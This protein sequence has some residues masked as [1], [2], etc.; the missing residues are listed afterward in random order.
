MHRVAPLQLAAQELAAQ[1]LAALELAPQELAAQELAAQELALQE[2]ALQE[3]APRELAVLPQLAAI[4]SVVQAAALRAEGYLRVAGLLVLVAQLQAGAG[5][6][7][8]PTFLLKA[9]PSFRRIHRVVQPALPWFAKAKVVALRSQC[10]AGRTRW[11][12]AK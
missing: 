3:L 12:A 6:V 9:A 1:E 10:R 8:E 4:P 7:P 11:D 2:L 5:L